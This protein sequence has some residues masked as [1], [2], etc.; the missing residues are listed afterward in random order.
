M[1]IGGKKDGNDWYDLLWT[2]SIG[3][4]IIVIGFLIASDRLYFSFTDGIIDFGKYHFFIG[5]GII[6]SG[7]CY[8]ILALK[9]Y[10]E[11]S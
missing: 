3:V 1:P 10:L 9:G 7:I 2:L 5:I 11:E 4:A 6:A 8:L